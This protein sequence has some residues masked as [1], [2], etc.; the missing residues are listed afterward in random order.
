MPQ[1]PASPYF[2]YLRYEIDPDSHPYWSVAHNK[3]L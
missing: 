2:I 3:C 1:V